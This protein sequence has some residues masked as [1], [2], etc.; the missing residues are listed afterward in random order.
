[1][2][3][4]LPPAGAIVMQCAQCGVD[5]VVQAISVKKGAPMYVLDQ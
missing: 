4:D 1:M 3:D 5:I 2:N